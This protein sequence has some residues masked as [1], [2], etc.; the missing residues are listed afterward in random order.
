[1][2]DM[3]ARCVSIIANMWGAQK[4]EKAI[5]SATTG[6]LTVRTNCI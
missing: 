6:T 1:M 4:G 5:G 2:M 3:H